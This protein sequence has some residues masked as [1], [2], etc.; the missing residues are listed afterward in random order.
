MHH[1]TCVHMITWIIVS[2]H[3]HRILVWT[4]LRSNHTCMNDFMCV[5]LYVYMYAWLCKRYAFFYINR[6]AFVMFISWHIHMYICRYHVNH[7][8]R[9]LNVCAHFPGKLCRHV[10]V[11]LLSQVHNID[12]PRPFSWHAHTAPWTRDQ[13]WISWHAFQ[14][15]G[16]F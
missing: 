16:V 3:G 13:P 8:D 14:N 2:L 5:C 15:S 1:Y 9:Y 7:K 11:Y 4:Y 6:Y 12:G 10:Y